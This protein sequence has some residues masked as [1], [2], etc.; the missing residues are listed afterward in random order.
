ME[1]VIV[2]VFNPYNAKR[3]EMVTTII[4][5]PVATK[6]NGFI[7][8]YQVIPLAVRTITLHC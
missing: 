3:S 8:G 2:T 4:D 6:A 5:F 1:S 7:A